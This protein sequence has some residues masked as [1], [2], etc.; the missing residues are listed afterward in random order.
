MDDYLRF[1]RVFKA[2]WEFPYADAE[3]VR[4]IEVMRKEFN[5]PSTTCGRYYRVLAWILT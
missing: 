2:E 4:E 1:G 3:I 5:G